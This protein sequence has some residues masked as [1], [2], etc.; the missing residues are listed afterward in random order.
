MSNH[1]KLHI[2]V[3]AASSSSAP[4]DTFA[5]Q[6]Q[7]QWAIITEC[8]WLKLAF[9]PLIT[10]LVNVAQLF[11]VSS[12]WSWQTNFLQFKAWN[13]HKL[14]WIIALDLSIFFILSRIEFLKW[15]F[16][17]KH[18]DTK[19]LNW[20]TLL[21]ASDWIIFLFSP[22]LESKAC[23][24]ITFEGDSQVLHKHFS[25]ALTT[26]RSQCFTVASNVSHRLKHSLISYS[27]RVQFLSSLFSFFLCRKQIFKENK[28]LLKV[29]NYVD[30]TLSFF[31]FEKIKIA[32][33]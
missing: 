24:E 19:F 20:R 21:L 25:A 31:R 28:A 12:R 15:L 6:Y 17:V 14:T 3:L 30:K 26:I 11:Y 18:N 29:L 4:F 32:L 5:Q 2:F 9:S 1:L 13:W 27:K 10:Q 33:N 8:V 7:Q 16:S 23:K 22:T